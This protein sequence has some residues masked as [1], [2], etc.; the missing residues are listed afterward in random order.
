MQARA[1]NTA[2]HTKNERF[3]DVKNLSMNK[4]ASVVNSMKVG[5]VYPQDAQKGGMTAT[6]TAIQPR[7]AMNLERT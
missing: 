2:A 6:A 3:F 7:A 5:S 1:V 4:S